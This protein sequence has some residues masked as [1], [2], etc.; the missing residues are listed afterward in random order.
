MIREILLAE[1]FSCFNYMDNPQ[2]CDLLIYQPRMALACKVDLNSIPCRKISFPYIYNHG[3]F[4]LFPYKN[5]TANKECLPS[6][7]AP[8]MLPDIDFHCKE[9]FDF[10]QNYLRDRERECDIK[11]ADFIQEN[12]QNQKLFNT[13]NHP[14]TFVMHHVANEILKSIG[15]KEIKNRKVDLKSYG[16]FP[17]SAN[18]VKELDLKYEP[19]CYW[20]DF[21]LK[22]SMA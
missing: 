22:L 11:V 21:Y 12:Y 15:M 7:F 8:S 18:A 4:I 20:K 5:K 9:R 10:C 19:D 2:E 6:N 3:F 13:Q 16:M 17:I 14:S 1:G